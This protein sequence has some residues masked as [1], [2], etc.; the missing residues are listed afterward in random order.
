MKK[1]KLKWC[2]E[3]EGKNLCL[4][5]RTC[6]RM[7]DYLDIADIPI[8]PAAYKKMMENLDKKTLEEIL[9]PKPVNPLAQLWISWHSEIL[10]H[11]PKNEMLKLEELGI[12]PKE[13][14]YFKDKPAPI[15]VSCAF[16]TAH[17]KPSRNKKGRRHTIRS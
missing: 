7:K 5:D 12:T 14:L 1:D 8:E 13:L 11:P 16:G 10:K 3:S 17:K 6:L 15:C 9:S 2:V 4:D